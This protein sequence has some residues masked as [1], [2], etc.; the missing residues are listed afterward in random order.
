MEAD[1]A[2]DL[3]LGPGKYK[4]ALASGGHKAVMETLKARRESAEASET[5]EPTAEK[6]APSLTQQFEAIADPLERGKFLDVNEAGLLAE[7]AAA[8]DAARNSSQVGAESPLSAKLATITDPYRRGQF[9]QDNENGLL[10]ELRA[11]NRE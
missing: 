10:A 4:E 1:T 6:P 3:L 8:N 2:V 11:A 5:P 7:I 9:I